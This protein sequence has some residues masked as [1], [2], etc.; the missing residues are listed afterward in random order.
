MD[1]EMKCFTPHLSLITRNTLKVLN[2]GKLQ[3][4]LSTRPYEFPSRSKSVF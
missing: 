4:I 2:F 1:Q 3:K